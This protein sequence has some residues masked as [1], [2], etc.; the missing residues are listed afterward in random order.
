MDNNTEPIE[1]DV[2]TISDGCFSV[3][4]YVAVLLIV[5]ALALIGKIN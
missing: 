2:D 3:T 1:I 4:G 5:F